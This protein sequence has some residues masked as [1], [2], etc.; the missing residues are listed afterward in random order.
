MD[1]NIVN[2]PELM[3]RAKTDI[4]FWYP[5]GIDIPAGASNQKSLQIS[6]DADFWCQYI[7]CQYTTLTG[8]AADGGANGISIQIIDK[9]WNVTLFDSLI[10][11]SM[12]ASPGR[13]RSSGV[14]GDPSHQL[15]FPIELDHVFLNKSNIEIRYA[16][17]LAFV[18]RLDL[19]FMG[20]K[21]RRQFDQ[22]SVNAN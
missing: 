21:F 19:L 20:R 3:E 10:P 7:C 16:N 9:G 2:I 11:V 15:F 6:S 18:N 13:Q 14:A 4:P 5:F 1:E 12:F 17:S 22:E 8:A